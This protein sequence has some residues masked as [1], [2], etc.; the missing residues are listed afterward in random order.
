MATLAL[1]PASARPDSV[2]RSL[3]DLPPPHSWLFLASD[4]SL[5]R[6]WERH[7]G[8][9]EQL[10]AGPL[11]QAG[12][13]A[14]RDD[15]LDV[16]TE[17]GRVHASPA[18]WCSRL[19]ERNPMVSPLFLRCCHLHAARTAV[20]GHDD[21][22]LLVVAESAA[23]LEALA[24]GAIWVE[25]PR[26][27]AGTL[28]A[29]RAARVA[30]FAVQ[31]IAARRAAPRLPPAP[32]RRPLALLRTWVDDG[33][34]ESTG[35]H[36]RY[37]PGVAAYLERRG[38]AAITLPVAYG[39]HDRR[40]M[41]T[42]LAADGRSFVPVERLL[43]WSDYIHAVAIAA[44]GAAIRTRP[45]SI[46][47]LDV[48]ALFEE[49]RVRAAF[50][51]GTLQAALSTRLGRGLR[52]AGY[53][54]DLF[55][56]LFE[57]LATEKPI[58]LGLRRDCPATVVVSFQHGSLPPMLLSHFVTAGEAQFAPLPDRVVCSGEHFREKLVAAGLPGEMT[59]V[60]PALR[61]AHL[62]G[63]RPAE[64][65][66]DQ[67][68]LI[69]VTLPL[70]PDAAAELL[71]KAS[72][73]L[74]GLAGVRIALKPHPMSSR[75]HLLAAASVAALPAGF[76]VVT[77]A[78]G[79]WLARAS[80]VVALGSSTIYESVAAGVPVVVVG[81]DASLDLNPLGWFP[82]LARVFSTAGEIRAET[83]RLLSLSA[84]GLAAWR[85]RGAEVLQRSFTP[86]SEAAYGAFV[87][88]LLDG[89]TRRIQ[90]APGS[91]P[92]T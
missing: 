51:G 41:W 42:S 5:Q 55:V 15:F 54:P 61:F 90:N 48:T 87:D 53:T 68:P 89:E 22:T 17:L 23:M 47:G 58:L 81:R 46:A 74:D 16:I 28:L 56:D 21:G 92:G 25:R 32:A 34:L 39:I 60:G 24:P 70:Q 66:P 44:R 50:D 49:E 2:A 71:L 65:E 9:A 75:E 43:G 62:F 7:L 33:S 86:V 88:G 37:L 67:A 52:R 30:R 72:R 35:L 64:R 14:L 79:D 69:L 19:S 84:G 78:M 45:R 85:E 40:R 73:A 57:N 26:R 91:T 80:V 36:D 18:W 76:E 59:V 83:E 8:G 6:T 13:E 4:Y 77:G 63:E 29:R 20:S 12:A 38:I 27:R 3:A 82:D 10:A 31:S 11:V 1:S